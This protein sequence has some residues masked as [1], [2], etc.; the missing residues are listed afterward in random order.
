[1]MPMVMRSLPALV[2]G[3]VFCLKILYITMARQKFAS[4]VAQSTRIG[5]N[6]CD[7]T[8]PSRFCS[9]E[10]MSNVTTKPV[11]HLPTPLPT[12][13]DFRA[14]PIW[15]NRYIDIV[16]AR[17]FFADIA[18]ELGVD[19]LDEFVETVEKIRLA[20]DAVN[21]HAFAEHGVLGGI[22]RSQDFP[23]GCKIASD[24]CDWAHRLIDVHEANRM[25]DQQFYDG[26]AQ[27]VCSVQWITLK[28][29]E[30]GM[31]QML[32]TRFNRA[33]DDACAEHETGDGGMWIL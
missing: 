24:L 6:D 22:R 25:V 11:T 16:L 21:A 8:I 14:N 15:W 19:E 30:D 28:L 26:F 23:L 18:G 33:I 29:G 9:G 10:P 4:F 3:F 2:A 12:E 32:C 1:M 31:G 7:G 20:I 17:N 5:Y 13:A 27:C